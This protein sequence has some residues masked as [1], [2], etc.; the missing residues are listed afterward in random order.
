MD[1][2]TV[3][4]PDGASHVVNIRSFLER[5]RA[6]NI[7]L[8][9]REACLGA[10][11]MVFLGKSIS[12]AGI[13]PKGDNISALTNKLMLENVGQVHSVCGGPSYYRNYLLNLAN[14]MKPMTCLLK[15]NAVFKWTDEM[16][17]LVRKLMDQLSRPP[18]LAFPDWDA[19][20]YRVAEVPLVL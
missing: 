12:P 8:A 2:V 11:E 10:V 13:T 9:P 20:L 18:V 19:A 7:K 6:H 15:M 4:D 16:S 14:R 1:A 3:H 5:M 17:A